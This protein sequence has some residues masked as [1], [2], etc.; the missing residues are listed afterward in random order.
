MIGRLVTTLEA[1]GKEVYRQGSLTGE[2]PA[3]FYTFDNL[4]STGAM[5]YDDG[6]KATVWEFYIGHYSDDPDQTE[7]GLIEARDALRAAGF[8]VEGKGFD[9]S[10]GEQ[11]HTGR[12]IRAYIKEMEA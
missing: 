8:V 2:Y 11:T 4:N 5:H 7:Q 10:S 3:D 9:V 12:A 6:E 1:L